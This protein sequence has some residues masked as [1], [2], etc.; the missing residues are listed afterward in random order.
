[1]LKQ[2]GGHKF[3]FFL[4]ASAVIALQIG[5]PLFPGNDLANPR[6]FWGWY[7]QSEYLKQLND[8][9]CCWKFYSPEWVYPP[10]LGVFSLPF[11]MWARG[12]GPGM[13]A[14]NLICFLSAFFILRKY[15]SSTRYALFL[16]ATLLLL[17]FYPPVS[18]SVLVVWSTCVT[19]LGVAALF[20][21]VEGR[22]LSAMGASDLCLSALIIMLVMSTRPQDGVI[23]AASFLVCT[24]KLTDLRPLLFYKASFFGG[25]MAGYFIIVFILTGR[26]LLGGIYSQSD[27]IFQIAE[28]PIKF[29]GII[30]GDSGYGIDGASFRESG[31]REGIKSLV[32]LAFGSALLL[33][34]TY[35]LFN[36]SIP[37]SIC[38]IIYLT[39]YLSFSDFAYH[40][41]IKFSLFHYLKVPFFLLLGFFIAT[42]NLR[43][44][45]R[46]LAPLI[47]A[48]FL[49][50]VG[51]HYNVVKKRCVN[52]QTP[53]EIQV[54]DCSP[55]VVSHIL[56][57]GVALEFPKVY[58]DDYHIERDGVRLKKMT[59]YRVFRTNYG[60]VIYFFSPL[61]FRSFTFLLPDGAVLRDDVRVQYFTRQFRLSLFGFKL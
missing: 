13:I 58:F 3:T 18:D 12:A 56:I 38:I 55:G 1:M 27:H 4:F 11:A 17:R 19:M 9:Y 51:I 23:L 31:A 39:I 2:L 7:D 30:N 22:A 24:I 49:S 54:L 15:F 5:H 26:I 25:L 35:F 21:I 20:R 47:A 59:H 29:I 61:D 10:G 37:L 8:I 33:L 43:Q 48:A 50:Q 46:L 34:F 41:A 57:E 53:R 28:V 44:R 60:A 14:L 16:F 40:N 45:V 32:N 42:V 6:G 52:A 36:A